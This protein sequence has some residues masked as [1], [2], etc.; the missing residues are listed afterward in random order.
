MMVSIANVI[1]YQPEIK[2]DHGA[3]VE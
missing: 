2:S 3:L 1:Q